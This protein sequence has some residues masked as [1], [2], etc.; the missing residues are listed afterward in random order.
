MPPRKSKQQEFTN[1][2]KAA[3]IVEQGYSNR[4]QSTLERLT[5][6]ELDLIIKL[7]RDPDKQELDLEGKEATANLIKSIL[8]FLNNYK[9][10]R[11]GS[12]I[13]PSLRNYIQNNTKEMS[14]VNA[15]IGGLIGVGLICLVS[16]YV[17]IDSLLGSEKI[18][19]WLFKKAKKS[20]YP[21]AKEQQKETKNNG[22]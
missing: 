10:E 19:E 5:A 11:T 17:V 8:D 16:L 7:E 3:F 20:E 4:A 13:N 6:E 1:K 15:K 9:K 22:L 12:E 18:K 21:N 14:I 2:E